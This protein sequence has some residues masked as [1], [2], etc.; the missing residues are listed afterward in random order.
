MKGSKNPWMVPSII[1]CISAGAELDSL[2]AF[3]SLLGLDSYGIKTNKNY[4]ISPDVDQH[5][6][7]NSLSAMLSINIPIHFSNA[8]VSSFVHFLHHCT[9]MYI[10]IFCKYVHL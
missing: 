1:P 5:T 6:K 3:P 2:A 8:V 9:Y 4:C 7:L 10:I